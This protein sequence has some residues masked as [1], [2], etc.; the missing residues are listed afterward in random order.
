MTLKER[1]ER[2]LLATSQSARAVSIG[3]GLNPT[4]VR[5]L[6]KGRNL[7]PRSD[8]LLRLAPQLR[9]TSEWLSEERGEEEP[10]EEQ[11]AFQRVQA[12]LRRIAPEDL[13]QAERALRGFVREDTASPY[14][15]PPVAPSP[16]KPGS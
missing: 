3:A 12:I 8:H 13:P 4:Y 2:R 9:T 6:L 10:S 15:E 7:N 16:R 14:E 11:L 5:D 1:I